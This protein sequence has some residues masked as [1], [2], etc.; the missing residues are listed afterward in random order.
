MP[1]LWQKL[2]RTPSGAWP[3]Y[4]DDSDICYFAR[5]YIAHGGFTAGQ[6]NDL[7]FNYKKPVCERDK[8][9]WRYKINAIKQF[10]RELSAMK[11]DDHYIAGMPSS[12][13]PDDPEYDNRIAETLREL[14]LLKTSINIVAP[15]ANRKTRP[16]LHAGGQTRSPDE[17]YNNLIWQGLPGQLEYL[18]LVDDVLTTGSNFKACQRLLSE[19]A[20]GTQLIGIFWAKTTWPNP[21]DKI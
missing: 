2:E 1:K 7:I 11:L 16:P 6:G 3:I 14:K 20:P 5:D 8:P 21:F 17:I 12:K 19:N 18:L 10:A 9:S 15:F 4:L 13:T